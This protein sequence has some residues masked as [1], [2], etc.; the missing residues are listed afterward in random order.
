MIVESVLLIFFLIE[1]DYKAWYF[2]SAIFSSFDIFLFLIH[3]IYLCT[4]YYN[5]NS[6]N[7]Q[8]QNKLSMYSLS[9]LIYSHINN[10]FL[11]NIRHVGDKMHRRLKLTLSLFLILN[12]N[13]KIFLHLKILFMYASSFMAFTS[14]SSYTL[15]IYMV[16]DIFIC[17][18]LIE[19]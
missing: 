4:C 8:I 10:S 6:L 15:I 7:I 9:F 3:Q 12:S 17:T 19:L 1:S 11:V 18:K 13:S 16:D 2:I 5:D 14:P